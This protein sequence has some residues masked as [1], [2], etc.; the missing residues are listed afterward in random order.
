MFNRGTKIFPL[1]S[2][3]FSTW[4]YADIYYSWTGPRSAI[5]RYE[6]DKYSDT[7]YQI[8][9]SNQSFVEQVVDTCRPD[10]SETRQ[11]IGEH[12]INQECSD[13]I[14]LK[15]AK[16]LRAS[17]ISE[18]YFASDANVLL[19][20]GC[21]TEGKDYVINSD[22]KAYLIGTTQ[23]AVENIPGNYRSTKINNVILKTDWDSGKQEVHV[24]H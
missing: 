5:I 8:S 20:S 6:A 1:I 24:M 18:L 16:T 2:Y 3:F 4:L 13:D 14:L 22:G 23:F 19:A 10:G 12:I 15:F 11:L 21:L 9:F 17:A 7:D